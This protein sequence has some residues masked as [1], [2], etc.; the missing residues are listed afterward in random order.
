WQLGGTNVGTTQFGDAFMRANFWARHSDAGDGYHVL[1]G[2]PSVAPLQ[3]IHVPADQ[4]VVFPDPVSGEPIGFVLS[5]WLNDQ[6]VQATVAVGVAPGTLHIHLFSSVEGSGFLGFHYAFDLSPITGVPGTQTFIMTGYFSSHGAFARARNTEVLGHEV[7]EWLNDPTLFNVVPAWQDPATPH[8]CYS[9][10]MEVA[11]PLEHTAGFQ[12]TLNGRDYNLPDAA[13]FPWF[14]RINAPFS[15]N[16]W[17]SFR[18]AFSSVSES[19]SVFDTYYYIPFDIIGADAT[20][21]TAINNTNQFVGYAVF[22]NASFSFLFYID[23]DQRPIFSGF[24]QVP[25]SPFLTIPFKINDQGDVV[26]IFFD[27]LGG[28][29]SFL[30]RKGATRAIDF[31]GAVATEAL[32]INSRNNSQIV[33]DYTDQAGI[34][35]G[36]IKD[37]SQFSTIDAPFATNLAVTAINDSQQMVGN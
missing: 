17:L 12:V 7:L 11:D 8:I 2:A 4:G 5:S 21:L 14:A 26:G 31:P 10:A 22:G 9:A 3:V 19:C 30:W 35:H 32:G 16:G 34:V 37:A 1:L 13:F 27:P 20:I 23:P 25:G 18:N 36:F 15:V 33:G 24:I 29:H 6:I 28:E